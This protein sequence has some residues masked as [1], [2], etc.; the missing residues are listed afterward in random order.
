VDFYALLRGI[1]Q[2]TQGRLVT[3]VTAANPA[4]SELSVWAGRDNPV[5]GFYKEIYLP[6]LKREE[7]DRMVCE[8]GRRMGI[9]YTSQA[10]DRLYSETGGHPSIVRRLCSYIQRTEP[11]QGRSLS[12][13]EDT[14][15]KHIP[16]FLQDESSMFEEILNRLERHF[17]LEKDLLLFIA[18]GIGEESELIGMIDEPIATTMRHLVGYQIVVR[19]GTVYRIKLDLLNHW[20]RRYRLGYVSSGE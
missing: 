12:V 1:S 3:I 19:E 6:P 5:F 2:T 8:L 7:C 18:E 17:P 10:L 15:A 9:S 11:W 13:T 14:V 16:D 20:L 4:I